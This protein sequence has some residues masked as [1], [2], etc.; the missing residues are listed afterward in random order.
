[1]INSDM[2]LFRDSGKQIP[3][4]NRPAPDTFPAEEPLGLKNPLLPAQPLGL[5]QRFLVPLGARSL[6]VLDASIFQSDGIQRDFLD[7]P[8]QDSPFF[9]TSDLSPTIENAPSV[10]LP[11]SPLPAETRQSDSELDIGR[12][13]DNIFIPSA[14][15]TS[16][17]SIQLQ[18][19][20]NQFNDSELVIETGQPTNSDEKLQR[21]SSATDQINK[22]QPI[23][24]PLPASNPD[25]GRSHD[26]I[27]APAS[28]DVCESSIQLQPISNSLNELAVAIEPV[29]QVNSGE[30]T[31]QF[32]SEI[33]QVKDSIQPLQVDEPNIQ[34]SQDN[35]ST[36]FSENLTETLIRLP[37]SINQSD[38]LGLN[39][40]PEYQA[41]LSETIQLSSLNKNQSE[42]LQPAQTSDSIEQR[43][44]EASFKQ[45]SDLSIQPQRSSTQSNNLDFNILEPN[46]LESNF[47]NSESNVELSSTSLELSIPSESFPLELNQDFQT[48][49]TTESSINIQPQL[50]QNKLSRSPQAIEP[51]AVEP[52]FTAEPLVDNSLAITQSQGI[53]AKFE[54]DELTS[55]QK[56]QIDGSKLLLLSNNTVSSD[57]IQ[58]SNYEAIAQQ[59]NDVSSDL[60]QRSDYEAIAQQVNDI[61]ASKTSTPLISTTPATTPNTIIQPSRSPL[62]TENPSLE[63]AQLVHSSESIEQPNSGSQPSNSEAF[64]IN[65]SFSIQSSIIDNQFVETPSELSANPATQTES[66][67]I[68]EKTIPVSIESKVIQP[69]E[70]VSSGN[71]LASEE[72]LINT[73]TDTTFQQPSDNAIASSL[74]LDSITRKTS[75]SQLESS[76]AVEN[77]NIDSRKSAQK[78]FETTNDNS[79]VISAKSTEI[80]DRA[81]H[82]NLETTLEKS[83]SI[84]LTTIQ[85][86]PDSSIHENPPIIQEA[87]RTQTE[88]VELAQS[89]NAFNTQ[90]NSLENTSNTYLES[91]ST[92]QFRLE[93]STISTSSDLAKVIIPSITETTSA[94]SDTPLYLESVDVN[95]SKSIVSAASE[96]SLQAAANI[97]E[98]SIDVDESI[99]LS[100]DATPQASIAQVEISEVPVFQPIQRSPQ[101]PLNQSTEPSITT[102]TIENVNSNQIHEVPLQLAQGDIFQASNIFDQTNL[103]S[104]SI[105]TSKDH[106]QQT[107]QQPAIEFTNLEK[108]IQQK[109]QQSTSTLAEYSQQAIHNIQAQVESEQTDGEQAI[110]RSPTSKDVAIAAPMQT[111]F[112]QTKIGELS[113]LQSDITSVQQSDSTVVNQA[114]KPQTAPETS[115]N[116]MFDLEHE[117]AIQTDPVGLIKSTINAKHPTATI[118]AALD[119]QPKQTTDECPSSANPNIQLPIQKTI[120][121]PVEIQQKPVPDDLIASAEDSI[122]NTN[123]LQKQ[124][125]VSDNIAIAPKLEDSVT[126]VESERVDKQDQ[127]INQPSLDPATSFFNPPNLIDPAEPI[128]EPTTLEPITNSQIQRQSSQDTSDINTDPSQDT[129]AIKLDLSTEKNQRSVDHHFVDSY[130]IDNRL[131]EDIAIAQTPAQV[132]EISSSTEE[133]QR[134]INNHSVDDVAIAQNLTI[135]TNSTTSPTNQPVNSEQFNFERSQAI[136]IASTNAPANSLENPSDSVSSI[137]EAFIQ[138]SLTSLEALDIQPKD[139]QPNSSATQINQPDSIP[140][141]P[142]VLQN[143]TVLRS[144]NQPKSAD[145]IDG[146]VQ[147]KSLQS[148][149]LQ[150]LQS[151]LEPVKVVSML[152]DRSSR[153]WSTLNELVQGQT[154]PTRRS[155]VNKTAP[156]KKPSSSNAMN[157][158]IQAKF[159]ETST[160]VRVTR[161]TTPT[162]RRQGEEFQDE[163]LDDID[164]LEV[165]AQAMYDR[166]RQRMRI[167][168]ERHGRD[169]SGRLPW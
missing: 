88:P 3:D 51:P 89:I 32:S 70:I 15:S 44:Q 54:P 81:T 41:T 125:S 10:A 49:K 80:R 156:S 68:Q 66:E 146:I 75:K 36:P 61:E 105:S 162:I 9:S 116:Q 4:G 148:Q 65:D 13:H 129:E 46:S 35:V 126:S 38:K 26:N 91:T 97:Y 168:Q 42:N 27:S 71:R 149:S 73:A 142:Q 140:Q 74:P 8:F 165:L 30:K 20:S 67:I 47:I 159:S 151:K 53:Q 19:I 1:M 57:L 147:T 76:E 122:I 77:I 62:P 56:S 152:S 155:S 160:P 143:L 144:L 164:Y 101:P 90:V 93:N 59:S 115:L 7:S 135:S 99:P 131:V 24:Q 82:Q 103:Q 98:P 132:N 127:F 138:R 86:S 18:P 134:S 21:S 100:E 11:R 137:P 118:H 136:D 63:L 120:T 6:S 141:L 55:Q 85:A 123:L 94:P 139:I 22:P 145:K 161:P 2:P 110:Q 83:V 113:T 166:L 107:I 153:Q 121:E 108:T 130:S 95:T 34:R 128:L 40:E 33:D 158:T 87:D 28:E 96:E 16:E 12:S 79:P 29:Q 45:S 69:K 167:E 37:N 154:T 84:D 48:S 50:T 72:T 43:S 157:P 104:E 111:Q 106:P 109:N 23:I 14:E 60:I 52:P 31:Q 112:T 117:S 58:R 5:N 102:T 119:I 150:T 64:S 17:P 78:T 163:D 169:Y 39:V 133:I 124:T 92:L 114:A 25:I